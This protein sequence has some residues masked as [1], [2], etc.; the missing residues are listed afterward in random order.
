[1]VVAVQ[2]SRPKSIKTRHAAIPETGVVARR[3]ECEL[4]LVVGRIARLTTALRGGCKT[5][6]CYIGQ[7]TYQSISISTGWIQAEANYIRDR[8]I[9]L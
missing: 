6:G 9:A 4:K 5:A 3:C 2:Q 7:R 1:M 8:C